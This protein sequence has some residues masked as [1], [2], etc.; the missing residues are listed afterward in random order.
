MK[1]PWRHLITPVAGGFLSIVITMIMGMA[2]SVLADVATNE[3]PT[4]SQGE[5][6]IISPSSNMCQVIGKLEAIRS[7][8]RE[9][10][11]NQLAQLYRY[12]TDSANWPSPSVDGVWRGMV[13]ID[14][15]I[16]RGDHVNVRDCYITPDVQATIDNNASEKDGIDPRYDP[17]AYQDRLITGVLSS[18]TEMD[19]F[20]AFK[21]DSI[22]TSRYAK[23]VWA[24]R[25]VGERE[26]AGSLL[27][28]P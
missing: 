1:N 3:D 28:Q 23:S 12:V 18:N 5:S 11:S 26:R 6:W 4:R 17:R 20:A 7:V 21:G 10:K 27:P 13:L 22:R 2:P 25:A 8:D 14:I 9:A 19:V 15:R 24:R 16:Q